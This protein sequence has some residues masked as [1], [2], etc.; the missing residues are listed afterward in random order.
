ME[1]VSDLPGDVQ[2]GNEGARS[3]LLSPTFMVFL[4]VG[5][6]HVVAVALFRSRI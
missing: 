2:L 1:R 6:A 3:Q 5:P 4:Y